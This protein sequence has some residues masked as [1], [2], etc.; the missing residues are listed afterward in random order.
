MTKRTGNRWWVL[1][2]AGAVAL[3][4]GCDCGPSTGGQAPIIRILE[5]V[6]AGE[7][8][9]VDFGEVQVN[10][11]AERSLRIANRGTL[12]LSITAVASSLPEFSAVTPLPVFVDTGVD[13]QLVLRFRPSVADQVVTATLTISSND[14]VTP[15]AT[16][17]VRGRGIAAQVEGR[18]LQVD[19]GSVYVREC[20]A[21]GTTITLVN[22]GTSPVNVTGLELIDAP[23]VREA[24]PATDGGSRL[25]T[26]IAAGGGTASTSLVWCPAPPTGAVVPP[27][28]NGR[29]EAT[30]SNELGKVVIPLRGI[31]RAAYPR[32]C[33]Q[34]DEAGSVAQCTDPLDAGA[35]IP[36]VSM[37]NLCDAR[38]FPPDGGTPPCR[39]PDAG[40]VGYTRRMNFWFESSGNT[41]V[42][43]TVLYDRRQGA[44]CDAG[45]GMPSPSTFDF[46]FTNFPDSGMA[47][48]VSWNESRRLLPDSGFLADGGVAAPLPWR[49]APV[50]VT[51]NAESRC[52]DDAADQ[53]L[54]LWTRDDGAALARPPT[55]I[56]FTIRGTSLLPNAVARQA[57]FSGT[58]PTIDDAAAIGN[59]GPAPLTVTA[60][61]LERNKR[62]FVIPDDGGFPFIRILDELEPCEDPDISDGGVGPQFECGYFRWVGRDGGFQAPAVPFTLPGAI[63]TTEVTQ[64]AGRLRFGQPVTCPPERLRD[65]GET[66]CLLPNT[67][68]KIYVRFFT[69]DPY[70]PELVAPITAQCTVGMGAECL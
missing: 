48:R 23:G 34:F 19:F 40:V 20:T 4:N 29:L 44:V 45:M 28:L 47:N 18:P 7:R 24:N 14:P 55:G 33:Y 42:P 46:A 66:N 2:A 6:G 32:L 25:V 3:V 31:A 70:Q 58:T 51:Y 53:A 68:Q 15:G 39:G 69:N 43:Y 5:D 41:I 36:T 63:A 11:N 38:L 65:G 54:V 21:M 9:L 27:L 12:G 64:P 17:E 56:V 52:R 62:E 26:Q 1:A 30:L 60:L 50:Q 22:V 37:G 49:S 16:I 57:N 13:T 8:R 67:T 61:R 10:T 35:Q 59:R